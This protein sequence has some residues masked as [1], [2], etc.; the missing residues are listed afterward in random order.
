MSQFEN[1]CERPRFISMSNDERLQKIT[2]MSEPWGGGKLTSEEFAYPIAGS[3]TPVTSLEHLRLATH[4]AI[5]RDYVCH[6][7][8]RDSRN[9]PNISTILK[10]VNVDH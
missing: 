5:R 8:V 9:Q 3:E 1:K 7:R 10:M 4:L 6:G 2:A